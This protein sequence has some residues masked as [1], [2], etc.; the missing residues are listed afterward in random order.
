MK[1]VVRK[2]LGVL[3]II[4]GII[5]ALFPVLPGWWLIFIGLELLGLRLLF[6]DKLK[7]IWNKIKKE[8]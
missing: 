1:K 2:I 6:Q 8:K 4:L 3:A 7:N 5:G